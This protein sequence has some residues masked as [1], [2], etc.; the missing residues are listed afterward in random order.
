MKSK[1][2]VSKQLENPK[3]KT[4]KIQQT[5][6]TGTEYRKKLLVSNYTGL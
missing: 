4:K 2:D 6:E 1:S 5:K 3:S